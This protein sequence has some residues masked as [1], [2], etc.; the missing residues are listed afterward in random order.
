MTVCFFSTKTDRIRKKA[1]LKKPTWTLELEGKIMASWAAVHFCGQ[2]FL[3]SRVE[4]SSG[5][6]L[7]PF[8]VFSARFVMSF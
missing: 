1:A 2:E 7:K 8:F 4:F 6:G 3:A 5:Q